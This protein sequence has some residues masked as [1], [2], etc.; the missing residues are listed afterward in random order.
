MSGVFRNIAPPPPHCPASVNP[1][2]FGAGG[3][4]TRLGDRGWGVNSSEDAR[5]CSVRYICKYCVLSGMSLLEE[6]HSSF[7]G[8]QRGRDTALYSIYVSTLYSLV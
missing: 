2:A 7:E 3:G 4:H 6:I 5:H 8:L 1:P